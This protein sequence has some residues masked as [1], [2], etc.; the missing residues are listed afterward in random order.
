MARSLVACLALCS[1][2][3]CGDSSDD[4]TA[5]TGT[6]GDTSSEDVASEDAADAR[7]DSGEDAAPAG[8]VTVRILVRKIAPDNPLIVGADVCVVTHPEIACGVTDDEGYVTFEVPGQANLA[9]SVVA[10][11][12]PSTILMLA[13]GAEDEELNLNIGSAEYLDLEELLIHEAID[14]QTRGLINVNARGARGVYDQDVAGVE[15]ALEP[16]GSGPFY[17][18]VG[19]PDLTLTATTDEGSADFVNLEP[20]TY[21][22][23]ASGDGLTCTPWLGWE[24]EGDAT[25]DVLVQ[26]GFITQCSV[27]CE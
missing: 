11:G 25:M 27:V 12:F 2:F 10:E 5:D 19:G 7:G 26:P 16:A 18:T 15:Y 21:H 1:L 9:F 13:S 22:L 4:G 3:A 17:L 24:G 20:G 6:T 14:L 23:T 8:P